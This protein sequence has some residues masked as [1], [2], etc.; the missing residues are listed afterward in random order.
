MHRGRRSANSLG[1][2]FLQTL[3]NFVQKSM[4]LNRKS[5][6]N[7]AVKYAKQVST[8]TENHA[9]IKGSNICKAV[10]HQSAY[11]SSRSGAV[12]YG[13]WIIRVRVG[14][15]LG[16]FDARA[17]RS[18]RLAVLTLRARGGGAPLT[19]PSPQQI[20]LPFFLPSF[21]PQIAIIIDYDPPGPP[22]FTLI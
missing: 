5:C 15:R 18:G 13:W 6:N 17:H 3:V 9:I 7:Q 22:S 20:R 14:V 21:H 16:S 12:K 1:M 8:K 10:L 11:L 19:T 4:L 2:R